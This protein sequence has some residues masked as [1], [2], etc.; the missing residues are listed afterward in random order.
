VA[1]KY[2]VN[3]TV[4]PDDKSIKDM[5]KMVMCYHPVDPSK[6]IARGPGVTSG[7][8]KVNQ[9]APFAVIVKDSAGNTIPIGGHDIKVTVTSPTGQQVPVDVKDE[10]T[11]VYQCKYL[12]KEPGT[13]IVD[14]RAEGK[15]IKDNPFRVLVNTS[16]DPTKSYA[17]GP[18][19]HH[20]FDNRPAKFRVFAKDKDGK[21]VAG[22]KIDVKVVPKGG[23]PPVELN[24][25]DNGDG[26]YDVA[27]MA[28]KPGP[29]IIHTD[30][31]GKPIRDMPKEV[32][33]YPGVDASKTI[34]E[35][36]G[37]T[38][39]F[40]KTDLP[41]T[42]RA[43]DKEG[44]PVRIGGDEFRAA[45]TAPDGSQVPCD[46]KDN[47]DGTYSGKYH[48]AMPG[49]YKV[50]INVNKQKNPVGKSP[51]TA[52][53]RMGADPKNSFAVGRGWK[54]CFDCIPA[55]FTIHAKDSD[56][57]PVAGEIIHIVMKNV[58]PPA[59]KQKLQGELDKMDDYLRNKK[60]A[61]I[62]KEEEKK[63]KKEAEERKEGKVPESRV[64]SGGDVP[65]EIRD[66]GDGTY[67]AQYTAPFPGVYR[68]QVTLGPENQNIKES[69]KD[70]PCHLTRPK[71]VYW[72][73]TFDAQKQRLAAAEALLQKHGLSLPPDA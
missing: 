8:P 9:E 66:N 72:K 5:P 68:C 54:E 59:Q 36:P 53:V 13:F 31:G 43:M 25:T 34:V 30:I 3:V 16:A 73:H 62:K 46:I 26:T 4:G 35:G 71:I 45:V 7:E 21:P 39:G 20:A 19:L 29:Y 56:G 41:F 38:G 42:I 14:V 37:V 17:E 47:N 50:M 64:E 27:Y 52:K 22:E 60:L 57:N 6:C 61:K 23:G 70:I 10:N 48:A 55:R 69:P 44:K 40:A 65:V 1:G 49:N 15:P 2:R 63:R 58:T 18:G 24:C 67:L 28:D 12:P 11:G 51:Y 32:M 33:C